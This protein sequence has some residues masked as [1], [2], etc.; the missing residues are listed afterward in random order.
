MKGGGGY[1][2]FSSS[3]LSFSRK[4]FHFPKAL[5]GPRRIKKYI[6]I[7]TK[8]TTSAIAGRRTGSLSWSNW[9]LL[10]WVLRR[11][12]NQRT[13]RNPR[14]KAR[15]NKKRDAHMAQGRNRS[16]STWT[17]GVRREIKNPGTLRK[18]LRVSQ[19]SRANSIHLWHR[20]GIEFGPY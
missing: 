15:T 1:S 9:N 19:E 5:S 12:E 4:R 2:Q 7:F 8:K 13:E 11:E 6:K 10:C 16:Q 17:G 18:T 3:V 20:A 14:T